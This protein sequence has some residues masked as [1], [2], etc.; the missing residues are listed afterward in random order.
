VF[1]DISGTLGRTVEAFWCYW[2]EV[3]DYPHP[4]SGEAVR[5]RAHYWGSL[6]N[7]APVEPFV[8][9]SIQ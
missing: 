4:R 6:N 8:V 5:E 2:D 9:R 7:R 1:I 3:C